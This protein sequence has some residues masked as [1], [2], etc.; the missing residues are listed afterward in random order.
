MGNYRR[1]FPQLTHTFLRCLKCFGDKFFSH[2]RYSVQS[3]TRS[4]LKDYCPMLVLNSHPMHPTGKETDALLTTW[5]R[6]PLNCKLQSW[7]KRLTWNKTYLFHVAG[8]AGEVGR[9][10]V[11]CT[12]L[13]VRTV[14]ELPA[15]AV[16]TPHSTRRQAD[17]NVPPLLLRALR[18]LSSGVGFE[19]RPAVRCFQNSKRWY[20][21]QLA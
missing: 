2:Q 5:S 17:R 15:M 10:R 9:C 18:A 19:Q 6:P 7:N 8:T 13:G 14:E 16:F 3:D 12:E 11:E 1:N 20:R 4:S 21:Y